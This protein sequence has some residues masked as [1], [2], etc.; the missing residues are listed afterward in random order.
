MKKW[1]VEE[2]E[3]LRTW[4]S[5]GWLAK[6]IGNELD[7]TEKAVTAKLHTLGIFTK[8]R[9]SKEELLDILR[10]TKNSGARHFMDSPELPSVNTYQRHFGSWNNALIAAGLPINTACL[11]EDRATT[12]YVIKFPEFYKVG[13]TQSSID[14]RFSG[15]KYPKFDIIYQYKT[16]LTNA[17][18]LEKW[19]LNYLSEYMYEPDIF[20]GGHTECFKMS[21]YEIDVFIDTLYN[22]I[23]NS[24]E[25]NPKDI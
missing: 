19:C 13:I 15:K 23:L 10:N 25:T 5:Q 1:S 7:R 14:R 12:L 18:I 3:L 4:V 22:N 21:N 17:E 6:D 24:A 9:Y 11:Q 20:V 16:S 2:I 8:K